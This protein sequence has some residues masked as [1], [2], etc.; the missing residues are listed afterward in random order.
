VSSLTNQDALS[1]VM[2]IAVSA[3]L[4]TEIEPRKENREHDLRIHPFCREMSRNLLPR[5]R[6]FLGRNF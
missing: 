1:A 2:F 4:A 3:A 5:A 6:E